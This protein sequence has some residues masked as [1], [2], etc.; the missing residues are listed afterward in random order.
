MYCQCFSSISHLSI[1]EE[2]SVTFSV[3]HIYLVFEKHKSVGG[4]N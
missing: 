4:I 2:R 3:F 1:S